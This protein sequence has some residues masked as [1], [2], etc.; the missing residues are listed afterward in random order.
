MPNPDGCGDFYPIE[1][2]WTRLEVENGALSAFPLPE[3]RG[4]TIS[5]D[6][7]TL[8]YASPSPPYS[9]HFRNTTDSTEH[10][11]PLPPGPVEGEEIQAGGA[12]WSPDA[13]S[14]VL[15]VAYGDPCGDN[16]LSFSLV[17]VDDLSAPAISVLIHGSPKLL[18]VL[19]WAPSH[20]ILVKD[21]DNFSWWIDALTGQAMPAPSSGQP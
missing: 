21:W 3:G 16:P 2:E 15:S 9:L 12:I 10:F 17:R 18:R 14:F 19:E 5:R 7:L 11:L 13:S 1:P 4:H 20:R 6:G 8:I